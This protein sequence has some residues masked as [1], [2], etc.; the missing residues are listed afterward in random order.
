MY[1]SSTIDKL[2][3]LKLITMA[4]AYNNQRNDPKAQGLTFDERFGLLIDIEYTAKK[5][6]QVKRLTKR[7]T[8][9]QPEA[10][11]VDVDYNS[12]RKLDK[13]LILKLASCSYIP[14]A[15]GSSLI[16]SIHFWIVS[17]GTPVPTDI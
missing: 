9:D 5:S 7:A 6:E 12:G 8:F 14:T 16:S 17:I 15:T 13:D 4:D 1:Y 10:S 11:V 2:H 3:E